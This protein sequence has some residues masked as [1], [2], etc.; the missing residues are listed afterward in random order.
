LLALA[1]DR[2]WEAALAHA[3]EVDLN[4]GKLPNL[5]SIATARQARP[6]PYVEVRLAPLSAHTGLAAVCQP[7][8]EPVLDGGG[9]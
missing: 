5:G 1:R 3:I 2:I 8:A 7:T 4:A 9:A 6:I